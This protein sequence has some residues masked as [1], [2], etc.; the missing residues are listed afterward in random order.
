MCIYYLTENEDI[1][2]FIASTDNK[3]VHFLF[4]RKCSIIYS[5]KENENIC[6][7]V[8]S[9]GGIAAGKTTYSGKNQAGANWSARIQ[10]LL[11]IKYIQSVRTLIFIIYLV[12]VL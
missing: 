9:A 7:F 4:H 1:C 12:C 10:G 6:S 8:F 5:S 11:G 3:T 2:T